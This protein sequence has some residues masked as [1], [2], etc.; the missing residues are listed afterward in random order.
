[1][2]YPV[3]SRQLHDPIPNAG[4]ITANHHIVVLEGNYW[5]LQE[6]PW[7]QFQA[8]FDECIFLTASPEKLIDGLRQRHLCG[9]KTNEFIQHHM[10][11]VD[12]PNIERVLKNSA[13]AHVVVHKMDNRHIASIEY[14]SGTLEGR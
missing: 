11:T 3:Y 9:G 1:M 2:D 8:L 13:S 10:A 12:L 5:L 7:R 6:A 14:F 4:R